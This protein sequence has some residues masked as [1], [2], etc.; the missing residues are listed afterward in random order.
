MRQE[1]RGDWV[2]LA[3]LGWHTG[4]RIGDCLACSR[5]AIV[6]R[7]WSFTPEKKKRSRR[8]IRLPLPAYLARLI[9][10]LG[11]FSSIH[12]GNNRNGRVLADFVTW[13]REAGVDPLPVKKGKRTVHKKSFHSFRHS[14]ATRLAAVGVPGDLARMVTDHE[15]A[16]VARNY[17]HKDVD[18]IDRAL[19]LIRGG[20]LTRPQ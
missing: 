18:A 9:K 2:A 16:L 12:K 11:D 20:S 14:M 17:Q 8:T 15:S 5:E 6:E 10:R 1:G 7:V 3:L 4:Q 13:M 19:R